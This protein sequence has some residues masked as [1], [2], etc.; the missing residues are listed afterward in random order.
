MGLTFPT[1]LRVMHPQVSTWNEFLFLFFLQRNQL[2][3]SSVFCTKGMPFLP[4]VL[5]TL[6]LKTK[7]HPHLSVLIFL[8]FTQY[9]LKVKRFFH[10]RTEGNHKKIPWL[11]LEVHSNNDI[12]DNSTS[13]YLASRFSV[14]KHLNFMKQIMILVTITS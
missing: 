13:S 2:L 12:K 8:L 10:S 14:K 1:H 7:A 6:E 4:P 5:H 3:H 11:H 9:F